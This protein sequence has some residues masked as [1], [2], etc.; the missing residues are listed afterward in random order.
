MLVLVQKMIQLIHCKF[1]KN[2]YL[3]EFLM[4]AVGSIPNIFFKTLIKYIGML[5][6]KSYLVSDMFYC[7]F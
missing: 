6:P 4:K 1:G 2:N 3:L 5:K 7:F